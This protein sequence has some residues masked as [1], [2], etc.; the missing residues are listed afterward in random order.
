[1]VELEFDT[2]KHVELKMIAAKLGTKKIVHSADQERGKIL[3][4]Q[5]VASQEL[6][7]HI[8]AT[9]ERSPSIAYATHQQE[10]YDSTKVLSS[11]QRPAL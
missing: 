11:N 6:H 8:N 5:E 4:A 7:R 1:M 10:A 2:R 3:R 9:Y